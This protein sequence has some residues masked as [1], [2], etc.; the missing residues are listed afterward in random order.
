MP[1]EQARFRDSWPGRT[2]SLRTRYRV[3]GDFPYGGTRAPERLYEHD[4]IDV[5]PHG[6]VSVRATNGRWLGLKP[7]EMEWMS[8]PPWP[9][10]PAD[11]WHCRECGEHFGGQHEHCPFCGHTDLAAASYSECCMCGR[12]SAADSDHCPACGCRDMCRFPEQATP[13]DQA[14]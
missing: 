5:N 10:W 2:W 14:T 12:F 3:R 6:A 11:N 13:P 4:E 7:D 1:P 8:D 9:T